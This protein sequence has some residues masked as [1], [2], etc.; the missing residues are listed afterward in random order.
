MC[1]GAHDELGQGDPRACCSPSTERGPVPPL[2]PLPP[3][4]LLPRSSALL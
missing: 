3:L 1:E 2:E 4:P